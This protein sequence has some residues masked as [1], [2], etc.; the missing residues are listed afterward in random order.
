MFYY[1][2]RWRSQD[3]LMLKYVLT[4]NT[5]RKLSYDCYEV[6]NSLGQKIT[7]GEIQFSHCPRLLIKISRPLLSIII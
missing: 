7:I 4:K 5:I 1:Q 6:N 3:F 2:Y